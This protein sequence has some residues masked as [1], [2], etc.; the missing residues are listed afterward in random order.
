MIGSDF[1]KKKKKGI[2][3]TIQFKKK[4]KGAHNS[5]WTSTITMEFSPNLKLYS[6]GRRRPPSLSRTSAIGMIGLV[7]TTNTKSSL[8]ASNI[9]KG[10]ENPSFEEAKSIQMLN[11]EL[12]MK[13]N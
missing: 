4:K 2:I 6:L 9:I 8:S 13:E 11:N 5:K 1:S 10:V 12:N 7:L 3:V